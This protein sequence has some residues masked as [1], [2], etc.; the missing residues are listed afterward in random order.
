LS[1]LLTFN[2][3]EA[4]V[5]LL[6]KLGFELDIVDGLAGRYCTSWDRRMRPVPERARLISLETALG[7]QR[8][9]AAIAHNLTDL[10]AL[11]DLDL[12][13]VLILHVSLEARLR[14]EPGA[15]S[16]GA[17]QSQL[18]TYLN[19]IGALAVAVS[20]MKAQ[21]WGQNCPVIRPC[22]DPDEYQGFAGD[23]PSALRV[24][25][26]VRA[27]LG[28]FDWPA[29]ERIVHGHPIQLVGHNPDMDGSAP[30]ES[31]EQL[32]SYYRRYR[33][34]VH[35]AGRRLDDGYNLAVVEAMMTGMP[36]VS[37]AGSESPVSDGVNGYVS[38]DTEYLNARLGELLRD[39]TRARELGQRARETALERFSVD[40]FVSGWCAALELA[41]QTWQRRRARA[42]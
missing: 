3:H 40:T 15:P 41:R 39:P 23:E 34:Y 33:A 4:Y 18:A 28:R 25:N 32:R 7:G 38:D 29:H 37:Q 2:C 1:R 5:H 6:G 8:Y 10:L 12:P 21:S 36:V 17:L 30:A 35:S 9:D 11:R 14:E 26:Q 31:W 27:R 22:A 13:K 16:L 24:A 42:P 20:E 19:A